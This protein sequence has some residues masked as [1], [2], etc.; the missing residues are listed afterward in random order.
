MRHPNGLALSPH[1][2]RLYVLD[3]GMSARVIRV[4]DV[5]ENGSR[6]AN[7]RAFYQRREGET[8]DGFR[9]VTDGNLWCGW[10]MGRGL[11]GVWVINPEGKALGHIHLLERCASLCFGGERRR[12]LFMAASKG[13]Y[14]LY[15]G[16]QG[17]GLG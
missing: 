7:G 13:L 1:E 11:D 6:L 8:P 10:G 3:G 17:A 14:A 5:A 15:V 9:C 2:R 16:A 12:R 4:F